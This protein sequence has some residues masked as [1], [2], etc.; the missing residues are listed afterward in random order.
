MKSGQEATVTIA[1]VMTVSMTREQQAVFYT[2]MSLVQ[3]DEL[4]GVLLALLLGS[5]G[6]HRFYLHENGWGAIYVLFFWTGIPGVVGLVEAFFMPGRVRRFNAAY[7]AW[8]AAHLRG[9]APA[10]AATSGWMADCARCGGAVVP[11][12]NFC[13]YCGLAVRV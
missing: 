4:L 13:S 3:K 10:L 6:A 12:S 11:G 8:I 1:P 2:Q 7:A 5:F 9:T